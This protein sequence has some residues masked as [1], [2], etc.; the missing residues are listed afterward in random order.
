[1]P[2]YR[3]ITTQYM[4]DANVLVRLT[5]QD[6]MALMARLKDAINR[7]TGVNLVFMRM[8]NAF[9]LTTSE[10]EGK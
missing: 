1:M 8:S 10:E 4:Q 7:N 9:S 3:P 2:S 5:R 6:S